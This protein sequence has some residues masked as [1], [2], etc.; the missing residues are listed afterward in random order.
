[1][2]RNIL[3][4]GAAVVAAMVLTTFTVAVPAQASPL[5]SYGSAVEAIAPP[6]PGGS[7][8]ATGAS[9]AAGSPTIS[10]SANVIYVPP[11]YP[12]SC[13]SGNLCTFVWDPN[14]LWTDGQ[15]GAILGVWALFYLYNCHEY[16]VSN[17]NGNGYY[18][19]NQTPSGPN[20]VRSYF[21]NVFHNQIGSYIT[22]D[23][24][25]HG[26]YNWNPVYYVKNC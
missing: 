11:G 17:W 12:Y 24:T 3:R 10:P 23:N 18:V 21:R 13:G 6:A 15:G 9:I 7:R 26:P 4:T 22:P 20:G 5:P 8:S 19:D 2:N 16:A 1:M 25:L 14:Y